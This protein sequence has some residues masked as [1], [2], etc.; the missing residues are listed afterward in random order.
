M[1]GFCVGLQI[2]LLSFLF[3]ACVTGKGPRYP[4]VGDKERQQKLSETPDKKEE[5]VVQY[6]KVVDAPEV[7]AELSQAE[8]LY[9]QGK[10]RASLPF[11]EK[12]LKDHPD[13]QY[14][15][16]INYKVGKFYFSRNDFETSVIYFKN[17]TLL[18]PP[19]KYRGLGYYN[20]AKSL[21]ELGKWHEAI[22][23]IAPI[24]V[25]EISKRD[26][27]D[28][29]TFWGELADKVDRQLET[30]L[31][32]VKARKNTSDEKKRKDLANQ[33][34]EII[35]SRLSETELL[36]LLEQFPLG[37]PS[38]ELKIRV[39]KIKLIQGEREEARTLLNL[40]LQDSSVSSATRDK[41]KLILSRVD[42]AKDFRANRIGVLLP[43]SGRR[44]VFGKSIF[45][46]LKL[47]LKNTRGA[48]SKIELVP[49]DSGGSVTTAVKAFDRLVATEQV[50]AVIG[51]LTKNNTDAILPL[52]IDYGV[53][54]ISFAPVEDVQSKALNLFQVGLTPEV[55]VDSLVKYAVEY[56]QAKNFAIIYPE[57]SYGG[58]YAK[59]YF[60][61]VKKYNG[62]LSAASSFSPGDTDFKL[63]VENLVA[64]ST[65]GARSYEKQYLVEQKE[66]EL[67]R[68][69]SKREI[70]DIELKPIIDFDVIFLPDTYRTIGQVVP[71][72]K[73]AGVKNVHV[74]GPSSWN[75]SKL[76]NRAG[77]YLG[78]A[79]FV[80]AFSKDRN[81]RVT[82]RLING[83]QV[84][85]GIQP[86][87]LVAMGYDVGLA[88][89][90][91]YQRQEPTNRQSFL[92]SLMTL[93]GVDGA[94][95]YYV[96]D[97]TRSPLREIQLFKVKRGAFSYV[98]GI[99]L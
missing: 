39:A 78:G 92:N 11:Y 25:E 88:L 85:K 21:A 71:T 55:E 31:A 91:I 13:G 22:A 80:D 38:A 57:D 84:K 51:P 41:A 73:Y 87:K 26:R 62:T 67:E 16:K 56:L 76:L 98:K 86:N 24:N 74:M 23:Q 45:E 89:E 66:K 27:Y 29:F 90:K 36:Y 6:R 65:P 53:P 72:L 30:V 69:L 63:P 33:V 96:W 60:D 93:G 79:I 34:S 48:N 7:R 81:N 95:G 14:V 52:S 1:R 20:A 82:R 61:A 58:R 10:I 46:G 37:F 19:S 32:Y 99:T 94:T 12:Y 68:K 75:N 15:D 64:M 47:A 9:S 50:V 17:I 8:A 35:D 5:E 18:D 77:P 4:Q 28:L 49:A 54:L 3:F 42:S 43:L 97:S 2:L 83:Y 59:A 40:I 44:A 70:A